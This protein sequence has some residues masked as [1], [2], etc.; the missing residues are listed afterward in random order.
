M[1]SSESA[2][3]LCAH[4]CPYCHTSASATREAVACQ[5][6]LARHH[7][8]CWDEA[9]CCSSCG[10]AEPLRA[11]DPKAAPP[12]PSAPPKPRRWRWALLGACL[13][14]LPALLGYLNR[15]VDVQ[16]FLQKRAAAGWTVCQVEWSYPEEYRH[17]PRSY[18]H[19]VLS[20]PH[21]L[22][23]GVRMVVVA[24]GE[25]A[26]A[27]GFPRMLPDGSIES[28]AHTSPGT[29]PVFRGDLI[30]LTD[31]GDCWLLQPD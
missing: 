25:V 30:V 17:L 6:C 11:P 27:S 15:G 31:E 5:R 8:A 18:E 19:L 28:I 12:P 22:H 3:A 21:R 13:A 16:R 10:S 1:P 14:L 9:G 4:R 23:D 29:W 2:V 7:G 26:D 24:E 20:A